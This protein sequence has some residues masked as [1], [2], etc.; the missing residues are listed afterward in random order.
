MPPQPGHGQ[1]SV[2]VA[3]VVVSVFV[4]G[5]TMP[6]ECPAQQGFSLRFSGGLRFGR[7]P[8]WK[9]SGLTVLGSGHE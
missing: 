3:G 7:P 1:A 8:G 2:G 5:P 9:F 6:G 4:T